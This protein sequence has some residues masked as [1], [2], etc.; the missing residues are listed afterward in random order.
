MSTN[1]RF[2]AFPCPVTDHRQIFSRS[3]CGGVCVGFGIRLVR[4][5]NRG[6]RESS[7]APTDGRFRSSMDGWPNS[8]DLFYSCAFVL[9]DR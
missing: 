7:S 5:G 1:R 8:E 9:T 4:E 2:C 6:K 3:T